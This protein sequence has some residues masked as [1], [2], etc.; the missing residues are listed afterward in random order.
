MNPIFCSY[1]TFP[2]IFALV[3]HTKFYMIE[4]IGNS[5]VSAILHTTTKIYIIK[6]TT[7]MKLSLQGWGGA[8]CTSYSRGR[9]SGGLG[10][11]GITRPRPARE[12][13]FYC[14]C[15]SREEKCARTS[16]GHCSHIVSH[17][18]CST[19]FFFFGR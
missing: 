12:V 16:T 17:A 19:I 2:C 7:A 15:S 11:P 18:S 4:P 5:N 9:W 6:R 1:S 13:W 8:L 3:L 10:L 14:P